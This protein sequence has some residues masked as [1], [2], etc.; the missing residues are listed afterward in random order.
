M[1]PKG[2]LCLVAGLGGLPSQHVVTEL[3]AAEGELVTSTL[4]GFVHPNDVGQEVTLLTEIPS[5]DPIGQAAEHSHDL[6]ASATSGIGRIE[7]VGK[8]PVTVEVLEGAPRPGLFGVLDPCWIVRGK[9]LPLEDL[10]LGLQML[11]K[12]LWVECGLSHVVTLLISA[13]AQ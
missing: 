2:Q 12:L 9:G 1:Q 7:G 11:E 5:E 4:Q 3:L 10:V 13:V 6:A 8:R